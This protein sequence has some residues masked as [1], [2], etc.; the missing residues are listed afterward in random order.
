MTSDGPETCLAIEDVT[1][2]LGGLTILDQVTIRAQQGRV[3]GLIG[4]NGAGKTT[5]FNVLSG[6]VRPTSGTVRIEG[7]SH[8]RV[9]P[10]DLTR[11]GIS[12][13]LQGVGL[14]ASLTVLENV[15]L[16]VSPER[17]FLSD[18]LGMPW[19]DR[20][21]KRASERAHEAL[22]RLDVDDVAGRLPGELPYP[23][24][25]RV[26]LARALAS[27]P[28]ILLLDEPAGGISSEDIAE[29]AGLMRSWIPDCSVLLVEHHM[30]LV[31]DVCDDIWVL[32][33]GQVIAHGSPAEIAADPKVIAA[34]LGE[35]VEPEEVA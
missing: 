10:H 4:P 17:G 5:V 34:Y 6:F 15:A 22:S 16:A 28:R 31:M 18:A 3:T 30:E 26:A 2:V 25:K 35:S 11:L 8:A 29:L 20:D 13:T 21:Q 27:R 7:S 23:V 1:V 9:R 12:R 24:Q 33:A 19:S 32:D 14:C